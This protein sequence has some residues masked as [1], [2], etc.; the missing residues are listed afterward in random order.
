[1]WLEGLDLEAS[2]EL[3]VLN[4]IK[5]FPLSPSIITNRKTLNPILP[6]S[7]SH[8]NPIPKPTILYGVE[9]THESW[10]YSKIFLAASDCA[11]CML[12]SFQHVI[13]CLHPQDLIFLISHHLLK[14]GVFMAPWNGDSPLFIIIIFL[15]KS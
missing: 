4:K 11:T 7:H 9:F 13:S 1:M 6:H 3:W 8:F 12:I 5:M 14:K 10:W 2:V 15:K